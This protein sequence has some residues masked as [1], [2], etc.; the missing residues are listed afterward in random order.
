MLESN[1]ES[2]NKRGEVIRK[3]IPLRKEK[4]ANQSEPVQKATIKIKQPKIL[5]LR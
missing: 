2:N 5:D 3:I 1:P 4:E